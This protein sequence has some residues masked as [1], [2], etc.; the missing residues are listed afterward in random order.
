M[1]K[2][3]VIES[4]QAAVKSAFVKYM[5]GLLKVD[6]EGYV[7]FSEWVGKSKIKFIEDSPYGPVR[8]IRVRSNGDLSMDRFF[9]N[10]IY[11]GPQT[12]YC[13]DGS[14]KTQWIYDNGKFLGRKA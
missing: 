10:F 1:S 4:T 7:D 13:I 12:D 2:V 11:D 5:A 14:I 6:H 8:V 9:I 3:K